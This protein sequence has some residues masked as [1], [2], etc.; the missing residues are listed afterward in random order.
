MHSARVTFS[1]ARG[2]V[3]MIL[4]IDGSAIVKSSSQESIARELQIRGARYLTIEEAFTTELPTSVRTLDTAA[5][6][7]FTEKM[8]ALRLIAACSSTGE[9]ATVSFPE[10]RARP[11][12]EVP[13]S[14]SF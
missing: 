10:R 5:D 14:A 12:V 8:A 2:M 13:T 11:R 7:N 3:E 9:A 6:V 4:S 1:R